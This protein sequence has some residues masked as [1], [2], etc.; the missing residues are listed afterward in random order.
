MVSFIIE[1]E[2]GYKYQSNDC[3]NFADYKDTG[4]QYVLEIRNVTKDMECSVTFEEGNFNEKVIPSATVEV[5][6]KLKKFTRT[7][8]TPEV[9]RFYAEYNKGFYSDDKLS[10]RISQ[11]K[12]SYL[13]PGYTF[14]GYYVNFYDKNNINKNRLII[15]TDSQNNA[16]KTT[17]IFNTDYKMIADR[18]DKIVSY[19]TPNRYNVTFN[20]AGGTGGTDSITATYDA[21]IQK[22]T[23]PT[24][25]GYVFNKY[26][27]TTNNKKYY[28]SDGT[29]A[30]IWDIAS[31]TSLTASWDACNKGSRCPGDNKSYLCDL[32]HYQNQTAQK[33]CK[34]CSKG[35]Y[36]ANKGSETCPK[37]EYK[38]YQDQEGQSSCKKCPDGM[39]SS[40]DRTYCF[41]VGQTWT[42]P[43][44]YTYDVIETG[45]YKLEVW[46]ASGGNNS[47]GVG[48]KGGHSYGYVYLTSGKRIHVVVGGKGGNA[49]GG[50]NGGGSAS[51]NG[52]AGGGATHFAAASGLLSTFSNQ[53]E[54]LYIVAGGGGGAARDEISSDIYSDGQSVFEKAHDGGH[55][56]GEN[57]GNGSG[58]SD[59][60]RGAKQK[61]QH[62]S[63]GLIHDGTFGKG[64]DAH[65]ISSAEPMA[66]GGGGFY[67]GESGS[68]LRSNSGAGGG[69]GYIG[70]VQNGVTEAGI[71]T[72]DGKA[73]ITWHGSSL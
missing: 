19:A 70:G 23:V 66:G 68:Y 41:P 53:V 12:L 9:S 13:S 69:S 64:G 22:I 11:V 42:S 37:C 20:K 14:H 60:S 5:D 50:Y 24:R 51:K 27:S 48:G 54:N 1:P 65:S 7:V 57:G 34:K 31:D 61:Q 10:K 55:G 39:I 49:D 8:A 63:S 32:G 21:D 73:S 36:A 72:G 25:E 67:G 35:T 43:G 6:T 59:L 17:L 45:Y 16:A 47:N 29:E 56:G 3:G 2:Q 28:N 46:G 30:E 44:S 4:S 33:D 71:Q 58:C 18:N 62:T 40:D 52:G 26:Y 15:G 38:Y